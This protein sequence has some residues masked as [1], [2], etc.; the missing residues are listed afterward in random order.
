MA[1][2]CLP[3]IWLKAFIRPIFKK[4]DNTDPSYYRPIALTCTLCKIMESVI[5]DHLLDF[6]LKN[7]LIS[8]DQ[9]GF[10]RK[11]STASNLRECTLDWI[12]G[13]SSGN[14]ITVVYIDFSRA[15]DSIV[16]SKLLF[17]L[18]VWHRWKFASMDIVFYTQ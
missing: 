3:L 16:S 5:K 11:H 10:M 17:K 4:D 18:E 14:H 1:I 13:L 6:L 9:Y 8:K 15:F 2:D 7:N 12:V